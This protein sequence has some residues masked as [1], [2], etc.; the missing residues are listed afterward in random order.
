MRSL[1]DAITRFAWNT[2]LLATAGGCLMALQPCIPATKQPTV[3][4][5]LPK[6]PITIINPEDACQF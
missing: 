6:E 5:V 4:Y 2:L 1:P 3:R